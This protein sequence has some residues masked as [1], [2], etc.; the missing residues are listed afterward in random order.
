LKE[1]REGRFRV[2]D[3]LRRIDI[4]DA[5]V[6][7]PCL[8]EEK[9]IAGI[10]QSILQ[11]EVAEKLLVVV[12][13]GGSSDSTCEIVS[14]MSRAMPQIRLIDNPQ[15]LQSAGINLAAK[16]FGAGRRWLIRM[17]AH[18]VYPP[19]YVASLI[20]EAKRTEASSVVVAMDSQGEH[21]FQRATAIA[22]NALL[23]T[24][25]S[26]H[27]MNGKE[28]FVD[29][30]HHA[31]FDMRTFVA[32]KGYDETQSHNEDAEYD[33]RLVQAGG[34]IWLTRATG[35]V[36]FPRAHVA[37]LFSQYRRYGCGRATTILRHH[38]RPKLRQLLPAAVAPSIV[39]A[40]L[41]PW[42]PLAA[43]PTLL[44]LGICLLYGIF[45]GLRT[46][47]RCAFAS[48]LAAIVM[49]FAWSVGFWIAVVQMPVKTLN[50]ARPRFQ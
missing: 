36:Y 44:W 20:A 8:N 4:D 13:D 7:I 47:N 14:Q 42:L 10:V 33:L 50:H 23:G 25:G 16:L 37:S 35:L 31:L 26:P 15:R 19:N 24:G 46:R 43:A 12:A 30:G 49:H 9:H 29:H 27:R 34:R 1:R 40:L 5:L 3:M 32:L 38:A 39:M 17:D 6:V 28:G 22:Q 18:A 11:D 21:C 48:G 41:T 45:L 2:V